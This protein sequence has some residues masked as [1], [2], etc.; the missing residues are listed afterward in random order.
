[1]N[2]RL[3]TAADST[4]PAPAIDWAEL[5][6][7]VIVLVAALIGVLIEAFVVRERRGPLQV[8]VAL[9]GFVAA[10]GATV[11]V[12]R[13]LP[14]HAEGTARGILAGVG[15]LAIDGPAV[16]LWGLLLVIAVVGTC[17]FAETR[18]GAGV[19]AF[20]GQAAAMP[21]SE[22]EREAA[23][24]GMAH[25]EVYPLL[26][27][28]VFGMMLFCSANDLLLMF[29]AL[30]ILSLPLY[31]LCGL[32]RRRRLLSQEAALKYFLLGAF[33]SGFFLY[34]AA[35]V[36][37]YAG[38]LGFAE[39]HTALGNDTQNDTML[40]VGLGLLLV[41]VLFKVGAAP[42]Q[43]WVPDV[44]TGAPTPVTAFM[45]AATKVAAFGAV[46]RLL[47]V[48][49]GPAAWTWQPV[50]WV[51]AIAS[52][53]L[54]TLMAITQD[55]VKRMLAYSSIGHTGFLLTGVLGLASTG[56]LAPGE[57]TSLQA[58]LFYLVSYAFTMLGAFAV[59]TLV[60]DASG[61]TTAL[62]RWAGLGQTS[63]ALA[64]SFSFL[65]LAMAGI[66]LTSG[67]ISKWSVFEVALAAGAWPVVVVA[68]AS[69]V[70]AIWLY[71]RV[72]VTMWFTAPDGDG[73]SVAVPSGFTTVALAVAVS[74]TLVLGLLPG[75]VLDLAGDIGQFVR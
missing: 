12:G 50:L 58:V 16:F 53:V 62:S 20:A 39:I 60:R 34:G 29:V 37:G 11:G 17:L 35:L 52:M 54:G 7:L 42:F 75:P 44:Y 70:V 45:A 73:P 5:S 68:I 41:G 3:F 28:A 63:P 71:L 49:F 46:L 38:S 43:A 74:M 2:A 56:T 19:P 23:H 4:V 18:L 61:E 24:R 32:A 67:F 26:G 25:T 47:Y 40:A 27:F 8:G 14:E 59:L 36:Y 69:S 22:G 48:A 6:P 55:D 15:T 51:I 1:M 66:P 9:V 13:G 21:G 57:L 65:L 10:F 33:A 72:I 31:L 30:E 64:A